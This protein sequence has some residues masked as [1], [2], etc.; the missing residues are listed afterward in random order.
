MKGPMGW[1]RHLR[2]IAVTPLDRESVRELAG[3]E[4]GNDDGPREPGKER[5]LCSGEN[6][7]HEEGWEGREEWEGKEGQQGKK[8]LSDGTE[9]GERRLTE[10]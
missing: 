2:E 9:E 8:R 1:Q 10:K 5:S 6:W 3:G 7:A 4:E